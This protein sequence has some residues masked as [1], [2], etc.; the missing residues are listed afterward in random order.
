MT[1]VIAKFKHNEHS[2]T[3]KTF[4]IQMDVLTLRRIRLILANSHQLSIV[5]FAHCFATRLCRA[6]K[7][8]DSGADSSLTLQLEKQ[9]LFI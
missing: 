8:S 6:I 9:L 7:T 2:L 1:P 3:S 5:D 4:L